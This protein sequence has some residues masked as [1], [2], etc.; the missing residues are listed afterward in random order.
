MFFLRT[1]VQ[2]FVFLSTVIFLTGCAHVSGY[3]RDIA[4]EK[5]A[6]VP[7]LLYH[8]IADL[9][10]GAG[11]A[12]RRWTISPEKFDAQMGWVAQ[13]GFH[14]VTMAQLNAYLKHGLPLPY[15]PIVISFDDGWKDQY[16]N[17]VPIL[18]KY[19]FSATFFIITD[20]VGHSDYMNWEQVREMSDS[21]MDIEPHSHTH[22]RLSVLPPEQAWREIS[23]SKRL[24]EDNLHKPVSVFA[25]P[26]GSYG[27]DVISMVKDAGFDSAVTVNGLN[28]G[29]LFRADRSYV[30]SRYAV[31]GEDNLD[32]AALLK[33]GKEPVCSALFVSLVQ[34][35]SIFSNR[36]G[37]DALIEFAGTAGIGTLFIQVYRQNK[38]WFPSEVADSSEYEKCREDLSEDPFARIIRLAHGKGIQVHAWLNLLSL[39]KNQDSRFLKKYGTDILTRNVK[40]K[41]KLSDYLIDEQYFLEPGDP[42]VREDLS[43]LVGELVRA[44]P[45]LDGIQFDYI[46]YPDKEPHYGYT[47]NNL[48]RFKKATGLPVIDEESPVWKEW[49]RAQ[50]TELLVLLVK[51][52]RAL[53]PGIQV[54]A[55]GC[56][57]Y[58]RAY[59]EAYQDWPSWVSLGIVDFVTL[60]NYSSDPKQFKRW[61]V[62]VKEKVPGFSKIKTGVGAYK[63][64]RAQ[65][66]FDRELRCVEK[67]GMTGALFHYGSLLENPDLKSIVLRKNKR[68]ISR[69]GE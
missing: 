34:D 61:L 10:A 12:Q 38:A 49:R 21:G 14:P 58:A 19:N 30:L 51:T 54:S 32:D 11:R 17:A 50:V 69:S 7:I 5:R 66:I 26:Y 52:A 41:N 42:R 48:E 31:E 67:L 29:Y 20:S 33:S 55:T 47:R 40:E 9:P 45:E 1:A 44:Y 27:E 59:H 23:G 46:R 37:I 13:H 64:V 63:F 57:P 8:H 56:M 65:K 60:M 39:A 2:F 25:Y 28:G 3:S 53:R 4:S 43:I 18:K 15:K 6:D 16:R 68:D 36:E 62:V 22:S 35:P 24:L